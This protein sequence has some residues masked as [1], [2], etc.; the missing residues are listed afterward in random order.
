MHTGIN[1]IVSNYIRQSYR[2]KIGGDI[3]SLVCDYHE[4]N[5]N[6]K[7]LSKREDDRLLDFLFTTLRKQKDFESIVYIKPTLLYRGSEHNF[8][9]YKFHKLCNQKGPTLTIIRNE[10][11]CVFGG[12]TS[13]EWE[14]NPN[15][16]GAQ[17]AASGL[18]DPT[19]FL[20]KIRPYI[21][22]FD[23]KNKYDQEAMVS[24]N[25]SGPVFG[26][27]RDLWI[28]DRNTCVCRSS[29]YDFRPCEFI[30]RCNDYRNIGTHTF[31]V[32]EYEVYSI[33]FMG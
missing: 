3:R 9:P 30:G 33:Q 18:T 15:G 32:L 27:G 2:G 8:C 1:N 22:K 28:A 10:Y 13:R 7:I 6:S 11:N 24:C 14:H 25:K 21:K 20:Y 12:Y 19:A 17:I 23:L 5:F 31:R 26:G 29:S 4:C 16:N